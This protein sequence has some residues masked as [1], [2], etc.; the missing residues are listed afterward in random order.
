MNT[1]NSPINSEAANNHR[2]VEA[3]LINGI[4]AMA[5]RLVEVAY[6]EDSFQFSACFLAEVEKSIES[7]LTELPG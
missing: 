4:L 6:D 1:C 3:T 5:G 2:R 7:R